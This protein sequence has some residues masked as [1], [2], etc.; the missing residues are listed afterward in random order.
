MKERVSERKSKRANQ[1]RA[2][3]WASGEC[4]RERHGQVVFSALCRLF[5]NRV[6]QAE[7]E[8]AEEK[9]LAE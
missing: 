9:I 6:D 1:N 7:G 5:Q 3:G 8:A 2:L 4:E